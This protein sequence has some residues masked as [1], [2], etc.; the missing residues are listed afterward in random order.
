MNT[1]FLVP[2]M[3]KYLITPESGG[4]L[5]PATYVPAEQRDTLA[6]AEDC[7]VEM[8]AKIHFDVVIFERVARVISKP[9]IEREL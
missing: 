4:N 7:A 6:E 1:E 9:E 5:H 8:A 3:K 2:K